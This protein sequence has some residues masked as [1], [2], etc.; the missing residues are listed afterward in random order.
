[1]Q[2]WIVAEGYC[3]LVI[4]I[5][6]RTGARNL[7]Q[8]GCGSTPVMNGILRNHGILLTNFDCSKMGT[9]MYWKTILTENLVVDE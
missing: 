5:N 1:V 4:T 8:Q 6:Y 3:T 2:N 9:S 7:Q